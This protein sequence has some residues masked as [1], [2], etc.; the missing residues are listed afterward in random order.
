MTCMIMLKLADIYSGELK[1]VYGTVCIHMDGIIVH[2]IPARERYTRKNRKV[3]PPP[4]QKH[5]KITHMN[6]KHSEHH[7]HNM[8]AGPWVPSLENWGGG[9]KSLLRLANSPHTP[10]AQT[11]QHT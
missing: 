6:T 8:G 1:T 3:S 2:S 10:S 9:L 5:T 7:K 11:Q 4:P